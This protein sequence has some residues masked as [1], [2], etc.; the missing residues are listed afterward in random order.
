VISIENPYV[1]I[2]PF[3]PQD[4]PHLKCEAVACE[5]LR[6]F[7][8][9]DIEAIRRERLAAAF[10]DMTRRVSDRVRSRSR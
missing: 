7:G 2:Q 8:E 5:P 9:Q 10:G 3:P 6:K 1:L 4:K